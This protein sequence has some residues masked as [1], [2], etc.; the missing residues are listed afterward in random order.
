ME[1]AAIETTRRMTE[2][3]VQA[4][5]MRACGSHPQVRLFRNS[6]GGAK[7]ADGRFLRYGLA[8][9]SADLI[10]WKSVTITPEMVGTRIA[11]F[12]SLEIKRPGK[13]AIRPEQLNWRRVVSEAGGLA[14][15][16]SSKEEARKTL[17]IMQ[18][19]E[20]IKPV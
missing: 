7:L 9:G 12:C 13:A 1:V 5:V 19:P 17:A 11:L 3:Q 18:Q 10:G 8:P 14:G 20:S 4:E 6:V 16:V 2:A 15:I